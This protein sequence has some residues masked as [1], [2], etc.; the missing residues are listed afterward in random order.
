M[1]TEADLRNLS[2]GD[3]SAI[4]AVAKRLDQLAPERLVQALDERQRFRESATRFQTEFSDVWNDPQLKKLAVTMDAELAAS[5][6]EIPYDQRLSKVGTELRLWI[7]QKR[8]VSTPSTHA[9]GSRSAQSGD[10]LI[11][12]VSDERWDVEA[13]GSDGEPSAEETSRDIAKLSLARSGRLPVFHRHLESD[14]LPDYSG[15]DE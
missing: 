10:R 7:A 13:T 12:R 5:D 9:S 4:S 3:E 2:M 8:G 1:S 11:R 15:L 6:P 14:P